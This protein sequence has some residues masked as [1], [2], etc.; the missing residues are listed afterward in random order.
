MSPELE[1]GFEK[2]I[3]DIGKSKTNSLATTAVRVV[4]NNDVE[5]K[6]E[7]PD[8]SNHHEAYKDSLLK[9]GLSESEAEAMATRLKNYYEHAPRRIRKNVLETCGN[10]ADGAGIEITSQPL[11]PVEPQTNL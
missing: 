10:I 5:N 2:H 1:A 7:L 11:K 6:T 3:D 9:L 8:F 4:D